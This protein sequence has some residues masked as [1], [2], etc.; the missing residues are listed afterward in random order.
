MCMIYV[1][2]EGGMEGGRE[3]DRQRERERERES[4]SWSSGQ[5]SVDWEV[6]R[7][8]LTEP[9]SFQPDLYPGS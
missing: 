5:S 8:R 4:H 9:L 7:L 3:T 6:E 1:E 2:R